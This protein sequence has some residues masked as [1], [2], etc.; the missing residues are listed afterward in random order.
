MIAVGGGIC[1]D[2]FAPFAIRPSEVKKIQR[3]SERENTLWA[4]HLI[5]GERDD[6]QTGS[7]HISECYLSRGQQ[8]L[9]F[10]NDD[11]TELVLYHQLID[12][13]ASAHIQTKH[14]DGLDTHYEVKSGDILGLE[15]GVRIKSISTEGD[16][17]IF[18]AEVK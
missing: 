15:K 14:Q 10:P 9:D 6:D 8:I 17:Y 7:L 1:T 3:G 11:N 16:L 5:L 4:Q 13:K 18:V 2:E 12:K